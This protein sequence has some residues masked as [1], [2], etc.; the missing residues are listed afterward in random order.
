MIR[1][2]RSRL[3]AAAAIG[4]SIVLSGCV[5]GL[6]PARVLP[7]HIHR[8]YIPEF[9]N[10]SSL[11]GAQAPLTLAVNDAFMSDGRLDVVQNERADMRLEGHI[12]DFRK[13][14]VSTSSDRFPLIESMEMVCTIELWDPYDTDR[15]A[16]S[17]RYTVSAIVQYVADPRRVI[18]ECETDAHQRLYEGLAQNIVTT[19]LTGT[20]DPLDPVEQRGMQRY[21]ERHNP[22]QF[23]P[24]AGEPRFPKI[25]DPHNIG[26]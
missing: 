10:V 16:P 6:A 12:K 7:E 22:E 5:S 8:I 13:S 3:L 24:A 23:E 26:Q 25:P 9:K 1:F 14:I 19:V 21:K 15:V 20:P 2:E 17:A 18:A 4:C 11:Y